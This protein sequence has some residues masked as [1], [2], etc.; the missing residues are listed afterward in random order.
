[1]G[2]YDGGG[3]DAEV[4]ELYPAGVDNVI[5]DQVEDALKKLPT[6]G[7]GKIE[8]PGDGVGDDFFCS[9]HRKRCSGRAV[10]FLWGR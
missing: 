5:T 9:A 3:E 7:E 10:V 4:T 8:L 1:M 6:R 2:G